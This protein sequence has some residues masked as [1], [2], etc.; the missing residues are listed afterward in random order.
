[1]YLSCS[2]LFCAASHEAR[3]I[4]PDFSLIRVEVIGAEILEPG[5]NRHSPLFGRVRDL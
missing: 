5:Q 4:K 2:Y 3:I 1:M